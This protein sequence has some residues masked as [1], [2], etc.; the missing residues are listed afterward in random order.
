MHEEQRLIQK[1]KMSKA[2][3]AAH[4]ELEIKVQSPLNFDKL[5][6]APVPAEKVEEFRD[7]YTKGW[8]KFT[9]RT[10]PQEQRL[11]NARKISRQCD[12]VLKKARVNA[13]FRIL[14]KLQAEQNKD[15]AVL[16]KIAFHKSKVEELK[17]ELAEDEK[18]Y[19]A[20][21]GGQN[22]FA[23]EDFMDLQARGEKSIDSPLG[24]RN[25]TK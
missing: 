17:K 20:L 5:D 1:L 2:D 8:E 14:D 18:S 10:L 13:Q 24:G 12:L 11:E 15:D 9:Y 22:S 23:A 21:E 6:P 4:A 3:H 16:E 7:L 19:C 25:M